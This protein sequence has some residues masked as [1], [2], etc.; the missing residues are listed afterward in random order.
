MSAPQQDQ[1]WNAGETE[2]QQLNPSGVLVLE[3]GSSSTVY[4][5]FI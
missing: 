1:L 4:A 3:D 2:V 5:N